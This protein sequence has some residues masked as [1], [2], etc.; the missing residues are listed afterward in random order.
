MPM[1]NESRIGGAA[2]PA[3][4]VLDLAPLTM[5]LQIGVQKSGLSNLCDTFCASIDAAL[6]ELDALPPLA[7]ARGA[8][9]P[10]LDDLIHRVRSSC[11]TIGAVAL[12]CEF[13]N[14]A[15]SQTRLEAQN[16]KLRIERVHAQTR[17]AMTQFL[18]EMGKA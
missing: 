10:S 6:D 16:Q 14:I 15:Q 12:G 18:A 7:E 5:L 2:A 8:D 3:G 4:D 1:K 13:R 9:Q 17:D 11:A